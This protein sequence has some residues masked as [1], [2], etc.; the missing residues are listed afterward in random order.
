MGWCSGTEIFD[1]V[2]ARV[3]NSSMTTSEK[4]TLIK[5]L[6]E[7]LEDQDWDCQNDSEFWNTNIVRECFEELHPDWDWKDIEENDY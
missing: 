1:V 2:V 7:V 4:K 6:I 3:Y 5:D